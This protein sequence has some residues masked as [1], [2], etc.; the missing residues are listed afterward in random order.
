MNTPS[1]MP[2]KHVPSKHPRRLLLAVPALFALFRPAHAHA[3]LSLGARS[4]CHGRRRPPALVLT[5]NC[6]SI[7]GVAAH[8]APT[9]PTTRR[10][11]HPRQSRGAAR[12]DDPPR[13]A[14]GA[15]AQV[16]AVDG[17]ITRGDVSFTART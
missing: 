1:D 4:R 8:A 14:T 7:A 13:P 15:R 16:L 2:S 10:D 3:I 17:H 5:F 6:V 12:G 11:R 9:P